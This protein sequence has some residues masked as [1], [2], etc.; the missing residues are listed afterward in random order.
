MR[1]IQLH[2]TCFALFNSVTSNSVVQAFHSSHSNRHHHH[3]QNQVQRSSPV[4]CLHSTEPKKDDGSSDLLEKAKKLREEAE[5]LEQKLR[6]NPQAS[7]N[8]AVE[9]YNTVTRPT[10][11]EESVWTF[12]YRFSS[13]PK[14]EEAEDLILPN[15]SGKITVR[16]TDDGYSEVVSNEENQLR[17]GKVW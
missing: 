5:Q 16:L 6:E 1:S 12:S 14:D 13:Q 3:H 8:A 15:Y 7:R 4:S 11:L 10:K 2:L 17:I 9:N